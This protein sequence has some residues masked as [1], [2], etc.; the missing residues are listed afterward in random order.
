MR[1]LI[2]L[3]VIAAAGALTGCSSS[4]DPGYGYYDSYYYDSYYNG[5]YYNGYYY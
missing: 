3:A 1:K 4:N 2:M 5:G